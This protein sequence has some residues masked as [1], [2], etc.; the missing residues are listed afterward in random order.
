MKAL[1]KP[2]NPLLDT[3]RPDEPSITEIDKGHLDKEWILQV[4]L[5]GKYARLQADAKAV[6]AAL[7]ADLELLHSQLDGRIRRKP[8]R[9]GL[10][11]VTEKGIESVIIQEEE[12]QKL[13]FNIM[14]SK[15]KEDRLGGIIRTLEHRKAAL[16]DLGQ[17]FLADYFAKPSVKGQEER[18]K[19][20]RNSTNQSE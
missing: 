16:Q 14:Q 13:Q 2:T 19:R 20:L 7:K 3:S 8:A 11:S 18:R 5:F 12:Y 6:H 1:K 4:K 15:L 10:K 9:Y 17:L